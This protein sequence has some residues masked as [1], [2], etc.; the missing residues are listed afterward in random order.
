MPALDQCHPQIVRALE[1]D[2]WAVD[3]FPVRLTVETR[4]VY[5]DVRASRTRNG[6]QSVVL[7]SEIKC[8]PDT[9]NTTRDLYT[10][11]G[12]YI[13]YRAMLVE[14]GARFP[15]YLTVPNHIYETAFDSIVERAISNSQINLIVVDIETEAVVRWIHNSA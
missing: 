12:Q 13:M 1:K 3:P 8:F 14:L 6:N 2:G 4:T 7:L 11:I 15:L 9:T 10:A 5:V